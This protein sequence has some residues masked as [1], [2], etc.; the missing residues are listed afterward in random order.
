MRDENQTPTIVEG[1]QRDF[2]HGSNCIGVYLGK[3][4]DLCHIV[5]FRALKNDNSLEYH[6]KKKKLN[7]TVRW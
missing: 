2:F 7:V 6:Y 4:H 3:I 1:S 5:L